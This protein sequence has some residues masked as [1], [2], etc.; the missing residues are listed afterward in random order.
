M[1]TRRGFFSMTEEGIEAN[2]AALAEI[3]INGSRDM[4]DTTLFDEV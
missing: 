4:F 3:G 1:E 2:L